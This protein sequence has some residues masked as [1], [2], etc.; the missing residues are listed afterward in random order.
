[1][2]LDGDEKR[3]LADRRKRT[4]EVLA[5]VSRRYG[6]AIDLLEGEVDLALTAAHLA[7]GHP[8]VRDSS[9]SADLMTVY[10]AVARLHSWVT[11]TASESVELL[12][13]GYAS[14]ATARWRTLYERAVI[15]HFLSGS[16]A[17]AAR[18][19]LE[20]EDVHL[21]K[22]VKEI[23]EADPGSMGDALAQLQARHTELIGQYGSGFRGDYG[24]AG[25]SLSGKA[26]DQ[27]NFME[28]EKKTPSKEERLLYRM[29]SQEVHAGMSRAQIGALPQF[30][31]YLVMGPSPYQL[32]GAG[33]AT[34]KWLYFS[35]AAL[36]AHAFGPSD[37]NG[38][39]ARCKALAEEAHDAFA[40]GEAEADSVN[41]GLL[42]VLATFVVPEPPA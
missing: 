41:D 22:L 10:S 26:T 6:T 18:R 16:G 40:D 12:R 27:G 2:P 7:A 38:L 37:L 32:A 1:M 28:I 14:G 33:Q 25:L 17:A 20:H 39:A 30:P 23:E 5:E 21:Y 8:A 13:A 3:R 36:V 31:E 35:T 19:Y 4:A 24:W 29:A 11:A 42:R 34:A 15:A 9:T